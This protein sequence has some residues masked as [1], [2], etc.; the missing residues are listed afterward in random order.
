AFES[1]GEAP[2]AGAVVDLGA[3]RERTG[4]SGADPFEWDGPSQWDIPDHEAPPAAEEER[5]PRTAAL[6]TGGPLTGAIPKSS[7]GQERSAQRHAGERES[8]A[9]SRGSSAARGAG[10]GPDAATRPASH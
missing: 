1:A 8:A 7:T 5:R 6:R 9:E 4:S 2:D 3:R 10:E